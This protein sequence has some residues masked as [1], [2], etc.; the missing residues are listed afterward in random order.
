MPQVVTPVSPATPE[1]AWDSYRVLRLT[2]QQ[3][4]LGGPLRVDYVVRFYSSTLI[5]DGPASFDVSGSVQLSLQEAM[6]IEGLPEAFGVITG[7]VI[8]EAIRAGRLQVRD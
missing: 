8:T 6:Q 1:T 3:A 2:M 5:Q 4:D 7:V